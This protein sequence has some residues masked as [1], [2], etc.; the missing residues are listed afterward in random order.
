LLG[1][2]TSFLPSVLKFFQAK[3]DNK[4]ELRVMAAQLE[5]QKILGDQRLQMINVQADVAEQDALLKHDKQITTKAGWFII[6]LAASVRPMIA[7]MLF[8]EFFLLTYLLA[9]GWITK[10]LYM[11]VWNEPTQMTFAAVVSFYFGSRSFNRKGHS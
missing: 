11:A 5:Q 9:A 2:G 7:Y 8:I 6:S 3:E 10:D 4:Q 1:F